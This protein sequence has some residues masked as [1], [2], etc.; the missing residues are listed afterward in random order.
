M[1]NKVAAEGTNVNGLKR[2][3]C[4]RQVRDFLTYRMWDINKFLFFVVQF[5]GKFR[6]KGMTRPE[7]GSSLTKENLPMPALNITSRKTQFCV[8]F[9][10]VLLQGGLCFAQSAVELSPKVG[11]PTTNF[12]VSGSHFP[13]STLVDIYFDT[14]EVALAVTN[15]SGVF[16]D[17]EI[18]AP[19][20]AL[21]GT[22]W[23]TV[24]VGATG[25]AA[26]VPFY[27][28]TNW[29]QFHAI[30]RQTGLNPYENVL[31]PTTAGGLDLD[32]SYTTGGQ[33]M[34]S[35]ASAAVFSTSA[36]EFY[37]AYIGSED[38]NVY[39]LNASTGDVLWKY[40]TGGQVFS[41]PAVADGSVYVGSDDFSIYALNA[42]SGAFEWKYGT[43]GYVWS[44]PTVA[45]ELVN[46]TV[47]GM[48]YVG[49]NDSN[50]YALNAITGALLW[51]YATG[52][53]VQSSPAVVNGVV[54]VTS[55][56]DNV[57]AL[58]ATTGALLWK[59]A[60]GS[61][62][63]SSPAVTEGVVYVS[64]SDSSVYALKASTGALLWKYTTGSIVTSSP[65]VADGVVYVGSND[66]NL[67]AL[68][69]YGGYLHWNYTTGGPVTS[70]PA[71]ANGVV[72]VGSN[73]G[74]VYAIDVEGGYKLWQYATGNAVSSSPAV[75]NGTVYV[76]STD[77]NVYAFSDINDPVQ[78]IERPDPATLRPTLR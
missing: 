69:A 15:I 56:D 13:A 74:N 44:S 62:I 70:S 11:P 8:A 76:G 53:F 5:F 65:A 60:T 33:G 32:W 48:V 57:Y 58:N 67:Y 6:F 27:V 21:P 9:L 64:S 19:A 41:S 37:L 75:A 3:Y 2:R 24:V 39:A 47:T 61:W 16:S 20:S 68:D 34:S 77:S 31:S 51:K 17:M 4:D 25:Q 43:G 35:P 52:N 55:G 73:D 1:G 50:V 78:A 42:Y 22:H 49:S 46:D 14:T 23:V 72:Y 63:T 66:D 45:N 26:Q 30:N 29:A 18:E 28:Q 38:D 7:K 40:A 12:E 10:S 59:Y 71:V 36:H 54:Y